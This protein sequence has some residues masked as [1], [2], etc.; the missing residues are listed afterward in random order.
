MANIILPERFKLKLEQEQSLEGIVKKTLFE[1]GEILAEN[2]LFF[3]GEYTDHGIKHIENVIASSDK[4][5]TDE[6][7]HKTLTAYDAAHYLLAVILHD[8]GMHINLDGFELLLEGEFNADMVTWF[9]KLTWSELWLEFINEA[10]RFSGKQLKAIFGDEAAVVRIP[11]L[12]KRGEINENDK[13]LIGEFIRRNHARLAHEI[14]LNGFPG[15]PSKISFAEGFS[16]DIK[17]LIGVIARSHGMALRKILDYLEFKHGKNGRRY[18]FN[19]HAVYLMV[20]LRV[21]DYIQIDNSRTSRTLMKSKTFSSP[22]SESEHEAHL[23]IDYIDDKY[24]EDPERIYVTASPKDSRMFIKLKRLVKDIQHEFDMSWAVL[25]EV[26]GQYSDKLE[27]KY[28]RI[29]SN[30]EDR[31]FITQQNYIADSFYFKA[32][33]EITKLLISPLYGDDPKYG[34]RELLQNAIDACKEREEVERKA[35]NYAYNPTILVEVADEQNPYFIISD[36]GIGMDEEIIKNYL[37]SAGASYRKSLEWQKEFQ[38]EKG[39]T[40]IRRS[41]RFGVGILASFLI[42]KEIYVETKKHGH[43]IGYKFFADLQ[44]EQINVLK[45]ETIAEGTII[46]IKIGPYA[47]SKMKSNKEQFR[48]SNLQWFQWFTLASP[49]IKYF[50]FGKELIPYKKLD[51]DI[52]NVPLNWNVIEYPGYNKILWTFDKSFAEPNYTCNGIVIPHNDYQISNVLDLGLILEEPKFSIFD[53]NAYTPI[54]LDRNSFSS[55]LPFAKELLIDIFKDY[56]AYIL[57]FENLTIVN[58]NSIRLINNDL[59]YPG[60][61]LPYNNFDFSY[62]FNIYEQAS[63]AGGSLKRFL[64]K[65]LVSKKGFI[66]DNNYFINRI[67]QKEVVFIQS[68]DFTIT[69]SLLK[70]DLENKFLSFTSTKLNAIP[71]YVTA[72]EARNFDFKYRYYKAFNVRVYMKSD[73]FKYL[74]GANKKRVSKWLKDKCI[75]QFEK[76]GWSCFNIDNPKPSAITENFLKTNSERINFIREYQLECFNEGDEIFNSLLAKYLGEDVIIPY[77]IEE[78]KKKYPLAFVELDRYMKKYS[79]KTP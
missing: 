68:T 50:F 53:N 23:A 76:N 28:R 32:N 58:E 74:F 14:A 48:T 57:T 37:L 1:F 3:F 12:S 59:Q 8:V 65:I 29:T 51:P 61:T 13:R 69:D 25:G 70:I 47:L 26:F 15:K 7:F 77:L 52:N 45:D 35:N 36:N 11:P 72:I 19:T 42:G 43:K 34:V 54:S 78:R 6:T 67:Q 27:I 38:D 21:S 18:P 44:T 71:D 20:L 30:L 17:D 79:K 63:N 9:D 62:G 22:I 4:L 60:C 55:K 10:K 24:Q 39:N 75:V 56:L 41:G 66:I 16:K 33:D 49:T 40:I 5:I 46:R 64:N 2:K 31:N 73:K